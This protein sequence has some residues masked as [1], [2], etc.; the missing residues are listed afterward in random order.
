MNKN[1]YRVIFNQ[2][3][4]Q[5]MVVPEIAGAHSAGGSPRV[6]SGA[7]HTL[8]Q[9][10]AGLKP[11]TLLT[12]MAL[13]LLAI[14]MPVQ[15]DI[16]ADHSAPGN[17]Q[18]TLI[19]SANGTPQVNIQT[20]S[21]AGVSRNTYSQFD[22][23]NRGAILNN[24]AAPVQTQLGGYVDGNPQVIRGGA[25]I[26]LN[27]VNSRNPSQLNGYVEV[28]GQKAQVVIANPSGI[29]CDGCGFINANRATLT[30]GTPNLV[31]GQLEGYNVQQ[32]NVTI[33][34]RGMDSSQQSYTDIIAQSVNVNAGV[35]ANELNVVTGKNKVSADASQI[36]KQGSSD[37]S[38][39]QFSMDVTALGGMYANTIRMVGTENGVGVHNAGHIG[40]QAGSVELTADGRIENSG[41]I[42]SGQNLTVTTT[43]GLTNSGTLFGKNQVQLSAQG[44]MVNTASGQMGT[45]GELN[46][47]TQGNLTSQGV[48]AADG[49]TR[50]SARRKLNNSG[51]LSS[52]QELR[53][54]ASSIDNSGT[55]Q[56]KGRTAISTPGYINQAAS[57]KISS[58]GFLSIDS[59]DWMTS[60]GSIWSADAASLSVQNALLNAGTLDA[61]LSL[62][63]S[64]SHIN[65]SGAI[66]AGGDVQAQSRSSLLNS[67]TLGADRD[68]TLNAA[69]EFSSN[70][71][72]YAKG[73]ARLTAGSTISNN[74]TLAADG[75]LSLTTP[76][77][78]YNNGTLYSKGN[79][80]LTADQ[81]V[82][83][84]G[85]IGA[86]G[87]LNLN[88]YGAL[89]NNQML[90]GK[91]QT[92]LNTG[93]DVTNH[94]VIGSDSRLSLTTPGWLL[95]TGTLYSGGTMAVAANGQVTNGGTLNS[96]S[97]L[98][99]TTQSA[100]YNG[101]TIYARG[102][103]SLNVAG[104]MTN[105]GTLGADR[106]L[107]LTAGGDILNNGTL[108]SQGVGKYLTDGSFTNN[109]L[110]H[111]EDSLFVDADGNILNDAD[112][113]A[114][115]GLDFSAGQ[116]ID[117]HA[118]LYSGGALNLHA[119]GDINNTS[120][121]A[122][123]NDIVLSTHYFSNGSNALLAAGVQSNGQLA[124]AGDITLLSTQSVDLQG[125]TLASGTLNVDANGINLA[126]G[127]VSAG[128]VNLQGHS[129]EINTDRAQL[130][131][132]NGFSAHTTGHWS[133]LDGQLYAGDMHLNAGSL[134]NDA[135]GVISAQSTNLTLSG[136]LSNRGLI[137]GLLTRLQASQIDNYGTGR[138][139]GTWL[140]LQA[141]VINN[142]EEDGTAATIAGRETLDMGVGTLNNYTH[143]LIFSGGNLSIGRLL[144]ENGNAIGMGGVLNNHSATIEALGDLRL[145]M[146][147]V[148]NVNDH[149]LTEFRVVSQENILEYAMNASSRHYFL[150]EVSF[151]FNSR[152]VSTLY[153]PD[154]DRGDDDYYEFTYVRTTQENAIV[155]TDPA[156]IL[157]GGNLLI[158]AD[159]V[160]N[161]KSQIVAGNV[162]NIAA[163]T[164][165]NTEISGTRIIT[166]SGIMQHRY[167]TPIGGVRV[168]GHH[169]YDYSPA[170]VY[171]DIML[172]ASE[173]VGNTQPEGSGVSINARQEGL[174]PGDSIG[175]ISIE[176]V[177][178]QLAGVNGMQDVSVVTRPPSLNLTLPN[179]SLY[180]INPA[181][182]SQYLVETDPKFT[183]LKRWL[184]SDYMTSQLKADPNNMHKRLGDGYYEQRLISDQII[185]L[186]G[187][188]F[189]N[190]YANDEEQYMALMNSGVEFAQKY[191]LSLGVALTK[192]QMANLTS[193]IVWLVS[194]D[195]TLPD[196]TIQTVLVPQ[197][198]AM[199]KPQDIDSNGALLAGKQVNLQLSNDLVNQGRILAGDKLNV[200]AQNIQNM[201]GSISGNNVALLA[202]NDINN[203]G[204]LIQ[205][206]DSLKLQAGHDINI[207]TT[208]NHNEKGGTNSSSHTNIN[209]VGALSVNND[210]GVLQLSSGN[211]INLTAALIINAGQNSETSIA[212]GHDLNMNT[213]TEEKQRDY[214]SASKNSSRKEA[215]SQ[216]IGTQ[217]SSSGNVT[218]SAKNDIN[219]KAAQ[220]MAD[221]QL[222][223]VAGNDINII[224]GQSTDHVEST[225]KS[226]S[227]SGMTKTVTTK[228]VV[229]DVL[230]AES[231]NF[232]GDTVIMNAGNDLR[233]E[234]SQIT[235]TNDMALHAGHD[236]TLTTAQEQQDDLEI[237]RK[238]K[239]GVMSSGGIGV[240][241]G[242]IDEKS[243]N[244]SHRVTQL[245]S[246][247]GST[248][249]NVTLSAGNNLTVKGS[250]VIAQ[251]NIN[252]TGKNVTVE[253]V[254]NQ[255][256][257]QDK[258][259]RTQSGVTIALSGAAGSALNAAVTEAKQAQDTQDS[260]IKAL[261]EIKAALSAVQA[262]Q[263]GMMDLPDSSE[264]FVGISI[265]GGTQHTESTTDTK[266]RA[267]QG[268]AIAAGNNLSI[269]ATGNGEKGVDGD[270]TIKGSAINAGNNMI[271]DA[272]RDVNL[273][274]AA[275]TQKTD[276]ENK[277]YGGN[278]GVSFGWGGGKNGLRFFADANFSQGN[279]HADG[280]YWTESQ[281]E[282]GNNLTII[283]GR[284]TNLIGALAKGDS[285]LMD[286]GRDLTVRSLQDTDDYSY[287]QYSL[288]IAGSYGTGFDGS[289]GFTMDK[290]DSTWA[291][292]NEQSG[293]YAGKGGYDITV[294]KHTQL[295]GAVI[296]SDATA[297][298]N[299]LDTG[300][301]G[302]SD[303]K[304]HADYD[305]SHVSISV[306]SGGG[307]PMGFPGTPIVVA[308]GDSASSTTHAAIA[309]GSIT[310]RDKEGQQQDIAAISRDTENAANPLDKIFNA[311]EEMRN[312][313]A[314]NLAGQIVSQVTTIATNIGVKAAQD[315]A[316]A[317]ADAQKDAAANDP[318][319]LAE[320]RANLKKAGNENPTQEDLNKATYDVVYQREFTIANEK[321]MKEY[322]TGSNVQRA[323]QAAGAALTVAMGGGSAGNAAAAASA[324]FL[325]QGVKKLADANFPIDEEHPNNANLFAKVIGHA[326]VGLAV[327][328]GSGNNGLSGAL[329]AASGELIAKAIAEDLYHK[330]TEDL[331]EA[332]RQF[333]ANMTS[334]ATGV[335]AGLVADNTANAGTAA[336]AAYNAAVNNYLSTE[337]ITTFTEK[338]ANAK[339]D[340]E[341]EQLKAELSQLDKDRQRQALVT[342]IPLNEQRAELEKLKQ[343]AAS[344][345]C[346]GQ[347]QE[348]VNYSISELEPVV[349]NPE[350]H[351]NNIFK[352][353]LAGVIY[354]LT[355]EKPSSGN[356][357]ASPLTREQ[358]QLIKNAEYITTAKGIQNPFPRDLNEKIVWNQVRANPVQGEKLLG[359]N[360]DPRFPTSAGFQKMEVSHKLPDGS[361]LTIHYQYNSYTGK[362]YD[363]KM[364]NPQRNSLQSGPSLKDNK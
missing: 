180:K 203:I 162:L 93:G 90:Y 286:V 4:G 25:K 232:S 131:V 20:P 88:T 316:H 124:N 358:E 246:T 182:G 140:G 130:Y 60:Y 10:I 361:S 23:D 239:S 127:L 101:N 112:I 150:D 193:D 328:E 362:A 37:A 290:M 224:A 156:K 102:H 216:D 161:D 87:E 237:I 145:S 63:L 96:G 302:W 345:D 13:G 253:S 59:G 46:V 33:Q 50:V 313:E 108:Y 340:E 153:T 77:A 189:L 293:I 6:S 43:E 149:F 226:T 235:S 274:A 71:T 53:V 303:I 200:L 324:P 310:I 227:R 9:L 283:S 285:V 169:D 257:I 307:A 261:Q 185:S 335:A 49:N 347:C 64:A 104:A 192:E 173:T 359:L 133:N 94:G 250:D 233:V 30:T 148:N 109:H 132:N 52:G 305:V 222:A 322:G 103:A 155:E 311:E 197:V 195:V 289:L 129:G 271:L 137:D 21:A 201:G 329:G 212:A 65:N 91:G 27:E 230:S 364:V 121:L 119:L 142:R 151:T 183:Q 57:G 333:I 17:Q 326:I 66:Y 255:T 18:P 325:A 236:L 294:G 115:A 199:V 198:Y 243:S 262:V 344:S 334:I 205:G 29:T 351:Q 223:V 179:A 252:L 350:L 240:T 116:R 355:V 249:G 28:A 165:N 95:N 81:S 354:G 1:L 263:A 348:L 279:M 242:K 22:V 299:S 164:L 122:A 248:E 266:I 48:I 275:N 14:S 317:K 337:D 54:S 196:G 98:F 170:A 282:A 259:E 244:T 26:I 306:G 146:G 267:A 314:I 319:I 278:A 61:G 336:S 209:Q 177:N 45:N 58:G 280:L 85:S 287:E 139:Y 234:G 31:N 176:R 184:G 167:S 11:L 55:L 187:Q 291:S 75:L 331:T 110:L 338:Y 315:E 213:V 254:E 141:D 47:T 35:W 41:T 352:G 256:N 158:T 86:D 144:D 360:S 309:D 12:S 3:R 332:E 73:N 272:N 166:E 238:K 231:S 190:G 36:E 92:T 251:Q 105:D 163:N 327:A 341:R 217:I 7:G 16:V 269:T 38:S 265:S 70:N 194:R 301:L 72:I 288:N 215:S 229:H 97:D 172:K 34:G 228:Q 19:S 100:L 84:Y 214:I 296:A 268:S 89:F 39:P 323:I 218:L 211:D 174:A 8:S 346:V 264:G 168:Q 281:L 219:A 62:T 136:L 210:N 245:A 74:G 106:N 113:Y 295:D 82:T 284:D 356:A 175:G 220:V 32:G 135:T 260:K 241:Y 273:L 160:N 42:S 159:T 225:S 128:A 126:D 117:N 320:A 292:V 343:L 357:N 123:L 270:I 118:Q 206:N 191:N 221:G 188:R 83:S 363:M 69:G 308:Y 186:T 204:G 157:A 342:G 76:G 321:Q 247:V 114:F 134:T 78:L 125:Q 79:L 120:T 44:D 258:Y 80:S 111:S 178:I 40:T 154:S 2:A 107:T 5:L 208:T 138:I 304:N 353:V 349:N 143:S 68:I 15:A 312:L 277:S 24:S 171:Q 181:V 339:T 147:Q 99:L 318:A 276:S 56:G 297:D 67:G 330:K 51:T 202:N 152:G 298:K 207:I 300:T